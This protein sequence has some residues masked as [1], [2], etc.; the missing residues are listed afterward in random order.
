VLDVVLYVLGVI[1]A[2][3]CVLWALEV[4]RYARQ[5]LEVLDGV[6]CVLFFMLEAME[7]VCRRP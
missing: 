6:R 4:M 2:V 5:M 7:D 1:K 3:W